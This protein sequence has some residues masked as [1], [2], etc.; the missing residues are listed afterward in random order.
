M[1]NKLKLNLNRLN[2]KY[3]VISQIA[4]SDGWEFRDWWLVLG[5]SFY[6]VGEC[7]CSRVTSVRIWVVRG[8]QRL[9]HA[10][11][12]TALAVDNTSTSHGQQL[13]LPRD[14]K[15][16]RYWYGARPDWNENVCEFMEELPSKICAAFDTHAWWTSSHQSAFRYLHICR[17]QNPWFSGLLGMVWCN[18]LICLEKCPNVHSGSDSKCNNCSFRWRCSVTLLKYHNSKVTK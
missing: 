11:S 8:R 3:R 10:C 14:A 2:C 4:L 17:C 9:V 13:L 7:D 5:R 16:A 6:D 18:I 12:V 15:H 1:R